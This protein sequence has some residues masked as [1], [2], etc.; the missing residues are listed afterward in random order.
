MAQD[1]EKPMKKPESRQTQDFGPSSSA[2]DALAMIL[3]QAGKTA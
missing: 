1:L 2:S 3:A